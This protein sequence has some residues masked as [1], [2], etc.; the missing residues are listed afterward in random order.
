MTTRTGI[1][2]RLRL[3]A[4]AAMGICLLTTPTAASAHAGSTPVGQVTRADY[5]DGLT[6][7]QLLAQAWV[8]FYE[9]PTTAPPVQCQYIGRTGQILLAGSGRVVCPVQLGSPVMYF[10]GG[11]CDSVSAP[12]Y[13][14]LTA[15]E[16]RRCALAADR[17]FIA[18]LHLQ[19]DDGPVVNIRT[20]CF[21]L[22]T[23]QTAVQ[24]PPDNIDGVPAGP[25]TFV[26]HAW[27]AFVHH[28]SLGR[29]TVTLTIDFVGGGSDVSPHYI[30]VVR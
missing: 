16:Q 9:T 20:P 3:A 25:A 14:G 5:A 29:H 11:T 15:G 27:G 8:R 19:V 26:A 21:S 4:A 18:G 7:A 24:L 28:L 1:R 17:G 13:F 22:F 12:P 30:D 10:F 23:R 6:G 2:S